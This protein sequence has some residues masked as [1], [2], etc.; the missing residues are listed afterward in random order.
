MLAQITAGY[1]NI[2]NKKYYP[3]ETSFMFY[4]LKNI[5]EMLGDRN[6]PRWKTAILFMTEWGLSGGANKNF[7]GSSIASY[8]F[9]I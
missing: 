4:M 2:K 1:F 9:A 7:V 8:Y 5:A 6:N 3:N